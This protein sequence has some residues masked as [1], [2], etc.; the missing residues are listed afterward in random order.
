[1][2]TQISSGAPVSG[3]STCSPVG[4]A[5]LF[6]RRER[7]FRHAAAA[8]LVDERGQRRVVPRGG[9]CHRCSAAIAM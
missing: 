9:E 1:L 7:G 6:L 8:A 2:A 4:F 5:L 3:C